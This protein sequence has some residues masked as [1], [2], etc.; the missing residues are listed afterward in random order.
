VTASL[1]LIVIAVAQ[2]AFLVLLMVFLAA[3]RRYVQSRRAALAAA[4]LGLAV[5]LRAWLA[6]GGDVT[7]VV[8]A[9]RSLPRASVVGYT[10]LLMRGTV[11][12]ERRVELAGPL[13]NEAW[14][15]RAIAGAPSRFWWRRIEAAR[16]LSLVGSASDR[17]TVQRLL[18]DAQPEV[19]IAAVA[20]L[21]LVAN[22]DVITRELDRYATLTPM[23]GQYVRA[24][25][26]EMPTLVDPELAARLQPHAEP[27]ALA[28]RV[29]LAAALELPRSLR[30]AVPLATH[31][32]AVVRAAVA[33]ALGRLPADASVRLLCTMLRD[34]SA[35]VREEAAASLGALG[36]PTAVPMLAASMRDPIWQVRRRAGLALAQLGEPGRSVVR[37]LRDDPDPY[38]ASMATLASGLTEGALLELTEN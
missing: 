3:R 15:Q 25:L 12:P 8:V 4:R 16:A 28:E 6:I 13:R 21:P 10:S 9:L 30:A 26:R 35:A 22:A 24:T 34:S 5:P 19:A 14:V 31:E 18:D 11:P 1:V 32:N 27:I 23:L 33:N 7:P 37:T 38:V 36:S 17:A 20:C 2:G 29:R